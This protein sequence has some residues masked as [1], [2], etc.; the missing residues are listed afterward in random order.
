MSNAAPTDKQG[1]AHRYLAGQM[2]AEETAEFETEMLEHPEILEEV[3]LLRRMKSGLASLRRNG[4]LDELVHRRRP[5]RRPHVGLAA[6]L[7]VAVGF[8]GWFLGTRQGNAAPV[9]AAAQETLAARIG[10]DAPLDEL[11]L[12][13]NRSGNSPLLE[14]SSSPRLAVLKVVTGGSDS[15]SAFDL[16]LFRLSPAP[17]VS[18][19][20]IE[21]VRADAQGMLAAYF[22]PG[23]AGTGVFNLRVR[24]HD[25]AGGAGEVT[26]FPFEV[27]LQ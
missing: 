3:A 11:L 16:E 2:S 14:L 25:A 15:D 9:F 1:K 27:R 13:R 7:I 23:A 5:W 8:I 21:A 12:V 4:E 22:D 26:D 10:A 19:G 6:G 17:Q 20:R 18:L 24:R